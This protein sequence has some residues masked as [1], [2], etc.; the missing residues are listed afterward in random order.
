MNV[1]A[2]LSRVTAPGPS[3]VHKFPFATSETAIVQIFIDGGSAKVAAQGRLADDLPWVELALFDH[4]GG[5]KSVP[6]CPFMRVEVLE[7]TEGATVSA[8]IASSE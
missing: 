6:S 2:L 7:L 3:A 1:N 4:A 5:I 8:S